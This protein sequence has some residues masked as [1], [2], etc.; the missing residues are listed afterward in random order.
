M[1]RIVSGFFLGIVFSGQVLKA[2]DVLDAKSS[3]DTVGRKKISFFAKP[4]YWQRRIITE[5][6]AKSPNKVKTA[7]SF[8]PER[9]TLVAPIFLDP[10]LRGSFNL[11]SLLKTIPNDIE[12]I[13]YAKM[14]TTVNSIV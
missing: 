9:M 11:K 8:F 4:R 13:K 14:R 7:G 10:K 3:V 1:K 6:F 2:D 12:P 5:P